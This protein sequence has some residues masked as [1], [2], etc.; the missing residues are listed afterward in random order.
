MWAKV[1]KINN[2]QQVYKRRKRKVDSSEYTIEKGK[3]IAMNIQ[4]EN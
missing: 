1:G 3:W 4:E 2:N